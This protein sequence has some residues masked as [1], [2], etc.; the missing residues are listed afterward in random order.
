MPPDE[1]DPRLSEVAN[2]LQTLNRPSSQKRR[3]L[4]RQHRLN[5][6]V[7]DAVDVV[8]TE[9]AEEQV[10]EHADHQHAQH[11]PQIAGLDPIEEILGQMQPSDET[12][13]RRRR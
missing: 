11:V 8:L 3:E 6:G 7:A 13:C 2:A 12:C 10:H 9:G 5:G 1:P 4:S